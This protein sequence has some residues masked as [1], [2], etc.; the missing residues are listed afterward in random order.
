VAVKV[1]D[2]STGECKKTFHN[3]DECAVLCCDFSA[4]AQRLITGD[5]AG[6]VKVCVGGVRREGQRHL[7]LL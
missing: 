7:S 6:S 4:N 2:V 1:W 5:I 3:G